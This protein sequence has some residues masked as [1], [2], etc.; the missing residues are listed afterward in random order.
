MRKRQSD[1]DTFFSYAKYHTHMIIS[2]LVCV[3][4]GVTH[5][6]LETKVWLPEE[7]KKKNLIGFS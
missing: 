1:K 3:C 4:V 5:T 2:L 6:K 7:K